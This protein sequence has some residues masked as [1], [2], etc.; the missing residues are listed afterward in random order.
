VD[1]PVHCGC[2]DLLAVGTGDGTL[3][4]WKAGRVAATSVHD[5]A[6]W[7]VACVDHDP[8]GWAVTHVAIRADGKQV[9]PR[10]SSPPP[11]AEQGYL[12]PL[13][14]MVQAVLVVACAH[15]R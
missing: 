1:A 3:H 10:G 13:D 2:G 9:G 4:V 5:G 7:S 12:A 8:K 6:G 11:W 15:S 14:H